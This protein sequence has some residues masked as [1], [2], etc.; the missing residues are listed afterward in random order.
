MDEESRQKWIH[1]LARTK[2]ES[3]KSWGVAFALSFFVGYFGVD[4]F[5]LG[6]TWSGIWKLLT[7][8]GIGIWWVIDLVLLLKGNLRDADDCIITPPWAV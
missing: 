3:D 8:G 6:Y 1:A 4:R 7:F 5:Y 2:E